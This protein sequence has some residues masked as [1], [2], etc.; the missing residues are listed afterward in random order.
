MLSDF[1]DILT[2]NV[3]D[4]TADTLC[5]IDDNVVVLGH[6]ESVQVLNPLS[7][8]VEDTLIDSIGNAVIDELRK[9]QAI[10]ALIEHLKGIGTEGK[11]MT[12]IRVTGEDGVYVTSEF[13]S[14][15]LVDGMCGVGG[16]A[17]DKDLS[18]LWRTADARCRSMASTT[19]G[20][21]ASRLLLNSRGITDFGDELVAVS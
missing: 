16:R 8:T 4:G 14:L 6:L 18:A 1:N 19:G 2:A 3:N 5:G 13:S 9:N 21:R 12:D 17:L 15:I 10:L 11:D 20:E 7:G